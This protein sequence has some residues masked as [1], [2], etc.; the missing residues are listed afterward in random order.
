MFRI[1]CSNGKY[2][3]KTTYGT[4]LAYTKNGKVFHSENLA[5]KNLQLCLDHCKIHP[6]EYG[7]KKIL[8]FELE[9]IK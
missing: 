9:I 7:T 8:T 1:K 4:H 3:Q 5:K 2:V 6:Y